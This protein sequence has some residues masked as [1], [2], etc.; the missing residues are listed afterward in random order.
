[1]EVLQGKEA[2]KV[3][4]KILDDKEKENS[5]GSDK[6]PKPFVSGY[7]QDDNR[8]TAFDNTDKCCWVTEFD[9]EAEAAEY[10]NDL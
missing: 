2:E 9:T 8:W 1:M 6:Y 7:F 3:L 10:A 4:I 5:I